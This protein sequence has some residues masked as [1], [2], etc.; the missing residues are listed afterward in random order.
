M[1]TIKNTRTNMVPVWLL[2]LCAVL[3]VAR[4][5]CIFYETTTAPPVVNLVQWEAFNPKE[6]PDGNLLQKPTLLLFVDERTVL[7][8]LRWQL[9]QGTIFQN[10]EVAALMKDKFRCVKVVLTGKGDRPALALAEKYHIFGY[11]EV[12]IA[13]P[14]GE[15]ISNSAMQFTD[16]LFAV[17]LNDAR[18]LG[19]KT[20]GDAA[21]ARSDFTQ[22]A[23]AY[24]KYL[25]SQH[26]D[27]TKMLHSML[28]YYIACKKLGLDAQ[29]KAVLASYP[30]PGDRGINECF[31]F[32]KGK[33]TQEELWNSFGKNGEPTTVKYVIAMHNIFEGNR[34]EAVRSLLW[35]AQRGDRYSPDYKNAMAEIKV[36]GLVV[37]QAP[38]QPEESTLED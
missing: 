6:K 13:L 9:V 36:Q 26:G 10:R 16:R 32:L 17:G 23:K 20:A 35:I 5:T 7:D 30:T 12:V 38:A 4:F 24:Q 27:E 18:T 14:N 19:L 2:L 11:P 37:P 29:A 15:S 34:P 22:A 28:R 31:E 3:V 8:K 33:M 25:A 21:M 1:L